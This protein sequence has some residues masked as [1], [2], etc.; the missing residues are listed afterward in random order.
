V[1]PVLYEALG[2]NPLVVDAAQNRPP[3]FSDFRSNLRVFG[4]ADAVVVSGAGTVEKIH[5]WSPLRRQVEVVGFT[6][7]TVGFRVLDYPF[8]SVS[9]EVPGIG[10]ASRVPGV[11]AC[12]LPA[13]R[14]LVNIEWTGNPL[15]AV[16]QIVAAL[17][18]L[19]LVLRRRWPGGG[20]T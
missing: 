6:P 11:V 12:R 18:M 1:G 16:G 2:A 5:R 19:G 4:D 17:T 7:V 9:T 10:A 14:H 15:S 8:W 20:G 3:A 13:G